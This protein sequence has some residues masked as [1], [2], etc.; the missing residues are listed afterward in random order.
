MGADQNDR[1]QFKRVFFSSRDDDIS[2]WFAIPSLPDTHIVAQIMDLSEDGLGITVPKEKSPPVRRGDFLVLTRIDSLDALAFLTDVRLE[3]K[4]ILKHR[5]L[6]HVGLG[7]QFNP[8][9]PEMRQQIA[10]FMDLWGAE[11]MA[12]P[13]AP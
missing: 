8:L 3:I 7:C 13:D 11:K 5:S 6:D 12:A 9:T 4:W 1:R 2:G 10:A